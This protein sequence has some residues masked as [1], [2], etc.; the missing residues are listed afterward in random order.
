MLK[1]EEHFSMDL[2]TTMIQVV[3]NLVTVDYLGSHDN[4]LTCP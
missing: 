2:K 4:K 3:L 1:V